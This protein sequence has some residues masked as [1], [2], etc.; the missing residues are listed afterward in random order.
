MS[1]LKILTG[2][3]SRPVKNFLICRLATI[4]AGVKGGSFTQGLPAEEKTNKQIN[5]NLLAMGL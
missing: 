1:L 2:A 3:S 4:W 5:K